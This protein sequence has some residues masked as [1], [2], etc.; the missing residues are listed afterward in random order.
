MTAPRLPL[1]GAPTAT[2]SE[3]P[4][5]PSPQK[6]SLPTRSRQPNLMTPL[7]PPT[8]TSELAAASP[9]EHLPSSPPSTND[10]MPQPLQTEL[11]QKDSP[12]ST[13]SPLSAQIDSPIA[14]PPPVDSQPSETATS[15]QLASVKKDYG[16]L[17]EQMTRWVEELDKRYPATLRADGA[18]GK[19]T[20][21]AMLHE[22]GFLSNV[23]VLKS[24]GNAALDQVAMEDVKNG[25]PIKFS[26]PLERTHMSVKFSITYDLKMAR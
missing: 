18:Q 9:Q 23:R 7:T 5:T 14:P 3:A 2:R 15:T 8:P 24:S 16:W 25:P 20:F 26:H 4:P 17:A 13:K 6:S 22:D 11:S 1:P 10:Q 21:I 19:V 12:P